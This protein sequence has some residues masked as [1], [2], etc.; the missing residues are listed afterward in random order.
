MR[1][2]ARRVAEAKAQPLVVER[3][4]LDREFVARAAK[5]VGAVAPAENLDLMDA[6]ADVDAH[7]RRVGRRERAALAPRPN[8]I[9]GEEEQQ[10]GERGGRDEAVVGARQQ[11]LAAS[12]EKSGGDFAGDEIAMAEAG[13]EKGPVSGDAEGDRLVEPVR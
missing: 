5:R 11:R 7:R 10:R 2:A 9:P 4:D 3:L 1:R 6:P 8:A 13:G 12:L